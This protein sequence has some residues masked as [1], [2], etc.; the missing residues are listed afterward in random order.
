MHRKQLM[1]VPRR[2]AVE[3]G[4][5]AAENAFDQYP[6]I[7]AVECGSFWYVSSTVCNHPRGAEEYGHDWGCV[8]VLLL[9]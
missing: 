7:R 9:K 2:E 6:N 5:T 8:F 4:L 3:G 1:P